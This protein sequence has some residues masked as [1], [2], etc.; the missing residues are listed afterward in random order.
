MPDEA[1]K[2]DPAQSA[3]PHSRYR[4]H[5]IELGDG[6]R[7]VLS[8]DGSIERSDAGG[9]ATQVWTTGDPG[10]SD[11]AIRFGIRPQAVT[12]APHGRRVQGPKGPG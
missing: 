7:L 3:V 1:I 4:R 11:Q 2:P 8:V 9:A 10:W 12:V 5:V 6:G